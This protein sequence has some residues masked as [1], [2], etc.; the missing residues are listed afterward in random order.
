MTSMSFSSTISGPPHQADRKP[1]QSP[2]ETPQKRYE[3]WLDSHI[4][5]FYSLPIRT[6]IGTIRNPRTSSKTGHPAARQTHP[7]TQTCP[8]PITSAATSKCA[9]TRNSLTEVRSLI[10]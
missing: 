2:F 5:K 8:L 1:F 7:I 6:L 9:H 4:L 10:E 3:N